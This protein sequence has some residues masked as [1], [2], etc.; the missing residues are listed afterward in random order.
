M[1]KIPDRP[2]AIRTIKH[3][4]LSQGRSKYNIAQWLINQY[5]IST[6]AAYK[7]IS[8]MEKEIA[9]LYEDDKEDHVA[10]AIAKLE[11][12]QEAAFIAGKFKDAIQCEIEISKLKQLYVIKVE[13]TN[14]EDIPLFSDDDLDNEEVTYGE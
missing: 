14:K 6:Q 2:A 3:M 7:V 12:Y 1:A 10:L 4:K 5:D 13:Q 8:E 9:A 11:M